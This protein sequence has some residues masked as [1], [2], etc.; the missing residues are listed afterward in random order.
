MPHRHL[1]TEREPAPARRIAASWIELDTLYYAALLGLAVFVWAMFGIVTRTAGHLAAFWP[2]NAL[3]LGAMVRFPMLANPLS[4]VFAALG[5]VL[6]DLASGGSFHLTMLLSAANLSGVAVGYIAFGMVGEEDRRLARPGSVLNL[7]LVAAAASAAAALTGAVISIALYGGG[8][9]EAW[10]FWFLTELLNYMVILP[11]MLTLPRG[12]RAVVKGGARR[13]AGPVAGWDLLPAF[14]LAASGAG[15]MIVGGPG[16]VAFPVP[17]LLW[18]AIRYSMFTSCL[19]TL[20]FA[21]SSLIAIANG[22]LDITVD[23][24]SA[25]AL[26]SI[27]LGVTLIAFAPLMV[28]SSMQSNVA[29]MER[30][31]FLANHDP[32]TSLPNRTAFGERATQALDRLVIERAPVAMLM[33]DI[34]RFKSINDTHGHV[35][36]DRVLVAFARLLEQNVR[37]RDTLARMGGE[38]FAVLLS[39]CTAAEAAAVAERI[40]RVFATTPVEIGHDRR[41]EVTVSIGVATA[42]QAPPELG[43]LLMVADEALYRAKQSGRNRWE[44]CDYIAAGSIG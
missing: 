1:T 23:V 33:L 10:V 16:A 13:A 43:P 31:R 29:L 44:A 4:W 17:A 39:A 19:L 9:G 30:L 26:L 40:C 35:A 5:F 2:A 38:E 3:M 24:H 8:F 12:L 27:R 25:Q 15:A 7:G 6:A 21:A 20:G 36:G 42:W 11:V 34:D 14:A 28:A 32:L 41:L 22:G 37:E 18:C